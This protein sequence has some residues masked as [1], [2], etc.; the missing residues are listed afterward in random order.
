VA[1][2]WNISVR[3]VSVDALGG[4]H[5]YQRLMRAFAF[6][7][8]T[9]AILS[10]PALALD[11]PPGFKVQPGTTTPPEETARMMKLP[12][13][14]TC[15]V[16]AAEPDVHQPIAFTIDDRGRLWVAENYS[17]PDW[18]PEGKDRIL[19]FED[20]DGDGK[21]DTSKVFYEG[22]N[23]ISA[24][25]VGF[26]GVFVG[27]NPGFYFVAD[28][29]ADDKPDAA[30]EMLLD[31]FGHEDMHEIL[32]SFN[33][34]PDGWL[35][36]CQGVFTNS[37]VG[38]P[39]TPEKERVRLN[40]GVWR[41][42]PTQKK[43]EVFAH[44]TSN[45][46]G[47][48]FNDFGHAFITAC[49]IPHL[50]HVVQGGL[51]QRQAGKHFNPSAYDDIKTIAKHRHFAGGDWASGSRLGDNTTDNAGGGHAHAGALLYL[52]NSWPAEFRNTIFMNNIHGNRVNN[53]SLTVDGS[54]YVGDRRPDFMKSGDKWFRGLSLK[55]APDGSVYVCDWYD[56]RACHQ[57]KPHDRTNGRIYKIVY[58]E[59]KGIPV[60]LAPLS[61]GELVK[62]QLHDNEW[63]VRHA[64]RLLQERGENPEVAQQ[65]LAMVRDE[66]L[67]APKRLRALWAL[68]AVRGVSEEVALSLLNSKEE[69]IR[70]W[71]VQL[72]CE[73]KTP[74]AEVRRKFTELARTDPSPIVRLYL[75]SAAQRMSLDD[76][77]PIVAELVGHPQD[78]LDHNLPMMLWYA[79]EPCIAVDSSRGAALLGAC[80]LPKILEFVARRMT[81][82]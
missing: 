1:R 9:L 6:L 40:A 58:K 38:P 62:L 3:D 81:T 37:N 31:G 23:N 34:G 59:T 60:N 15:K 25:E 71:T 11:D 43:F 27:S 32:N 63:Q 54:S 22:F 78:T 8:A 49:V 35:Y 7:F 73:T 18:K 64:R 67:T 19:I 50:Y 74:G 57:Q 41:W 24:I 77:W 12:E 2:V 65:L 14:F 75:A 55:L 45:P 48:D 5:S 39:G 26:G 72:I 51:Y 79:A 13:G 42:H 20:R 69:H 82:K 66:T 61:S 17:Y 4:S 10:S 16:F 36:G 29:D 21:F 46:W 76:R 53:D 80:K 70:A 30:P 52:G 33:W 28:K 44:G 47:V 56:A 68:H